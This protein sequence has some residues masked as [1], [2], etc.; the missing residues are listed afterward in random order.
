M[1][2]RPATRPARSAACIAVVAAL[3]AGSAS[4]AAPVPG[5]PA[6]IVQPSRWLRG[7]PI[8]RYE[9]GR[10][11]VIDLWSTWCRP[12][13]DSMPALRAIEEQFGDQV[14]VIAAGVWEFEPARLPAFL[15]EQRD[16][17]PAHVTADSV[18]TGRELNEGLTSLA[19]LGTSEHV[20]IPATF[21][22]DRQ[23]RLA[24]VGTPEALEA[25]LERV[26]AGTWDVT[27]FAAGYAVEQAHE[28]RFWELLDPVAAAMETGDWAAAFGACEAAAAADTSFAPRVAEQ[29]FLPLA[30]AIAA[31]T[32]PDAAT[33]EL[34]LRAVERALALQRAPQ[35][36]TCLVGAEAAKAAGRHDLA[37]VY[38]EDALRLAPGDEKPAIDEAL[39]DLRAGN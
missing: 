33:G 38:L 22:V 21:L 3:A 14:T 32:P 18:P 39:A 37:A 36:Q 20:A 9:P 23:G 30:G 13:L 2:H 8:E 7:E 11:Y 29:G 24:W 5:E 16:I 12:C 6:P 25:P 31:G 27:A 1:R 26:L 28:S 35:W 4:T 34:A 19:F 15:D 10:V 17:M